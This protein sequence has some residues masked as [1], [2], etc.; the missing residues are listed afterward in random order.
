MEVELVKWPIVFLGMLLMFGLFAPKASTAQQSEDAL[1][2]RG[3]AIERMVQQRGEASLRTFIG[4]HVSPALVDSVGEDTMLGLLQRI[5]EAGD[6]AGDIRFHPSPEGGLRIEFRRRGRLTAVDVAVESE[7]PGQIA[8]LVLVQDSE[9]IERGSGVSLPPGDPLGWD[10]LD[11]QLNEAAGNGFS[12][13]VLVARDGQIVT[14]RAFGMAD[15]ARSIVNTPN[16]IFAIGSTPIDFTYGAILQL[17]DQGKLALDDPITRFF[18]DVPEDKR[19]ITVGHLTRGQSGLPDFHDISGVDANPDLSW[20]D[21]ATAESRILGQPL[22]FEPGTSERH[23]HSAWGL[24]AAIVERVSGRSY[25]EFLRTTFFDP[26][27]MTRTGLYPWCE[28]FPETE[29]AVGRGGEVIGERNSPLY[30]GETSWL[31]M[32][33]GGMVSTCEDLF[34]WTMGI[35]YGDYLSPEMRARYGSESAGIGGNDRG[36]FCAIALKGRDYAVLCSNDHS[37]DAGVETDLGERLASLILG[38]ELR[39]KP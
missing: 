13:T 32:G 38:D 11:A 22:L 28:R 20:I 19:A 3:R 23:S 34:R 10:T 39:H 5:R 21:R 8:S 6:Q 30:W 37:G 18:A 35:R 1:R 27:G 29:I 31:V 7:S 16:T 4:E 9:P 36:F 12:G 14:H 25:A 33:S 17:A 26:M 24:L 2:L 15:D